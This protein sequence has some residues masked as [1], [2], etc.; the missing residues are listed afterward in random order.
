MSVKGALNNAV[1][2]QLINEALMDSL[3]A[4]SVTASFIKALSKPVMGPAGND[5]DIVHKEN[6]NREGS[7][8]GSPVIMNVAKDDDYTGTKA[9]W[10]TN[11][12]DVVIEG[13]ELQ[14]NIGMTTRQLME[15]A[16]IPDTP[17]NRNK[18]VALFSI[19]KNNLKSA[20]FAQGNMLTKAL[21]GRLH[22]ENGEY[23]STGYEGLNVV[24]DHTKDLHGLAPDGLGNF[25][26]Q[27]NPWLTR[28]PNNQGTSYAADYKKN[29]P[30]VITWN[31]ADPRIPA[32]ISNFKNDVIDLIV[33]PMSQIPGNWIC[34]CGPY[35]WRQ[36]IKNTQ[37]ND[38]IPL[39]IGFNKWKNNIS[40]IEYNRH[41][42]YYDAIVPDDEIWGIHVGMLDGVEKGYG[43][44]FQMC[45]WMPPEM[46][47]ERLEQLQMMMMNPVNPTGMTDIVLSDNNILAMWINELT[48]DDTRPDSVYSRTFTKSSFVT[49]YRWK[50]WRV[51]GLPTS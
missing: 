1:S 50:N 9:L 47:S 33:T 41:L 36:L 26:R 11:Y 42:F 7:Y 19:A 15:G 22:G 23:D 49:H 28:P 48:R 5:I 20:V 27:D 40:V 29:I 38:M 17:Q 10:S 45:E 18:V 43:A 46:G 37:G 35:Q 6:L 16:T 39:T 25:D 30:Q 8:R 21:A 31:S 24:L 3:S 51:D 13:D 12:S 4:L 2:G 32:S 34:P 14:N 44:G